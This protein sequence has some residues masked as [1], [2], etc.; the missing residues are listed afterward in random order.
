VTPD[1]LLHLVFRFI[2]IVSVIA[3]LGGV[4]YARWVLVPVL[5]S[6]PEDLRMQSAAGAQLRY[7][8]ILFVLLAL[9]VGSG[10]FNFLAGP[11][12]GET[13]QIWF[14]IKML[15]VAHILSAAILWASSPYGD[16]KI[17]GTSKRRL[18]SVAISGIIVVFISAWLRSLSQRGL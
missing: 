9:I 7:R 14:G 6:L 18:L 3:F 12:H 1:L 15:F 5:N 2:H 16:V 4:F 11:K 10:L 13:Y 17:A 8:R